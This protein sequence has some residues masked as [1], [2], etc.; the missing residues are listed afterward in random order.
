MLDHVFLDVIGALHKAFEDGFL[1]RQALEERFQ[2]DI[3]LGDL[4][5][6]TSYSLPGDGV[7]P[8]VRA[9]IGLDW[10]TWSQS[11]YR[12]WSVGEPGDDA[13]EI[14]IEIVL[15]IQRL[16]S[17]PELATVLGVLPAESPPIGTE[18]LERSGPTVEETYEADLGQRQLAV[19]VSYEGTYR[20]EDEALETHAVLE[21]HFGALGGWVASTLVRLGDLRLQFLPPEPEVT[22]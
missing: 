19:E 1:E 6:E 14:G 4:S 3:L 16:A 17:G 18:T 15:R 2:V 22:A 9:D 13:P 12:S 5:W 8:R 11:A 21:R 7:P 10:P 20:F